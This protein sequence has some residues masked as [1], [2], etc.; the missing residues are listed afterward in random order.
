[1]EIKYKFTRLVKTG[2]EEL[3]ASVKV[4]DI[5]DLEGDVAILRKLIAG[6]SALLKMKGGDKSD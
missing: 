4:N 6:L 2:T 1:M 5:E 3:S